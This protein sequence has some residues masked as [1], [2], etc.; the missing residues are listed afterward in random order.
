MSKKPLVSISGDV[1]E[2]D[3]LTS[4]HFLHGFPPLSNIVDELAEYQLD[5]RKRW[6]KVQIAFSV[7]WKKVVVR[8]FLQLS[9]PS[10]MES[11]YKEF[12][13]G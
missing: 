2:F 13:K 3:V 6:P 4:Y 1:L 5:T 8:I 12:K 11:E 9:Q 7:F 10:R